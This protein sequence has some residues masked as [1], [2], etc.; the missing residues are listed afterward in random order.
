M[1]QLGNRYG[2]E[3]KLYYTI[4]AADTSLARME[5]TVE[6]FRG[7]ADCLDGA[8]EKGVVYG[9]G[10]WKNGDIRQTAAFRA[11]WDM[12]KKYIMR[13]TV[14]GVKTGSE[15]GGSLAL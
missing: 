15:K 12:G 10:A 8:V 11:A 2:G 9:V 13:R 1:N 3:T 7:F 6:C 4:T 5:R 14:M